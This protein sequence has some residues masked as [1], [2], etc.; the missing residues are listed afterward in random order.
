MGL[1][2]PTTVTTRDGAELAVRPLRA[3]DRDVLQTFNRELSD[4]SRRLFLPHG[5]DDATVAKALA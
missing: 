3:S 5:Y 1:N 2:L 4:D